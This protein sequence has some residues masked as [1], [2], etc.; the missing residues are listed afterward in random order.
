MNIQDIGNQPISSAFKSRYHIQQIRYTKE[1]LNRIL[2]VLFRLSP[3]EQEIFTRLYEAVNNWQKSGDIQFPAGVRHYNAFFKF[4]RSALSQ[5]IIE[6]GILKIKDTD[7]T[8]EIFIK[9][10]L[11]SSIMMPI[12]NETRKQVVETKEQQI[13]RLAK[14]FTDIIQDYLKNNN[15][16]LEV[17]EIVDYFD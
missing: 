7:F 14:Y 6:G 16:N 11:R 8:L 9:E 15:N 10:M 4:L 1:K 5:L 13:E 2:N 17:L 3:Y 12:V